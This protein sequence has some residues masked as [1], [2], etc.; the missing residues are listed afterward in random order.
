MPHVEIKH[1]HGLGSRANFK[2]SQ[3]SLTQK[4]GVTITVTQAVERLLVCSPNPSGLPQLT[5]GDPAQMP[6][7]ESVVTFGLCCS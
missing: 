6:R 7:Y 5:G 4:G 1:P 2:L 3:K